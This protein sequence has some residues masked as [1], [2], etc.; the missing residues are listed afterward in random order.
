MTDSD[1]DSGGGC[2]T[3]R[4]CVWIYYDYCCA[5][6]DKAGGSTQYC[7][8]WSYGSCGGGGGGGSGG[9]PIYYGGGSGVGSY[10]VGGYSTVWSQPAPMPQPITGAKCL[11]TAERPAPAPDPCQKQET[12]EKTRSSADMLLR[13]YTDDHTDLSVKA[14][15]YTI[16]VTRRFYDDAW[17]FDHASQN[18]ELDFGYDGKPKTIVK[19]GAQYTKANSTGTIFA[20]KNEWKI[21]VTP[22]GYRWLDKKG[23]WSEHDSAGR[24]LTSA[25]RNNVKLFYDYDGNGRLQGVKD[26]NGVQV[27]WYSYNAAG[28]LTSVRDAQFRSVGYTYDDSGRLT[29]VA[30]VRNFETARQGRHPRSSRR[31]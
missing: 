13:Q 12:S 6:G 5:N 28:L 4:T 17:H 9:V 2:A 7:W 8:L 14:L 24:V 11:P 29:K 20:L 21:Y 22:T 31:T 1:A 25:N 10:A 3:Y 18:L 26:N 19:D 27:L 30:D 23:N 16:D 15:G